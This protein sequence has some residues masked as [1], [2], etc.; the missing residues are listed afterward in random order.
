MGAAMAE[1]AEAASAAV[2]MPTNI[3]R[4]VSMMVLLVGGLSASCPLA[5]AFAARHLIKSHFP[6]RL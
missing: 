1:P 6:G 3:R 5:R 4:V 2:L